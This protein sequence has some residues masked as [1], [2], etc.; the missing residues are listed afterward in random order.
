LVLNP[1][2]RNYSEDLVP[3][4]EDGVKIDLNETG[5]EVVDWTGFILSRMGHVA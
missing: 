4:W 3:M 1:G 2:R 5:L